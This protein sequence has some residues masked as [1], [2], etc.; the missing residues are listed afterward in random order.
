MQLLFQEANQSNNQFASFESDGAY[1]SLYITD[2]TNK[3]AEFQITVSGGVNTFYFEELTRAAPTNPKI[4][5]IFSE[6]LV[7][8]GQSASTST[9][10]L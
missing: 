1:G 7:V 10:A 2:G 4:C 6:R 3:I 5:S 9:V 8:A